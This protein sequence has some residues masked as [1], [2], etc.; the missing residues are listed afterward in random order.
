MEDLEQ[1]KFLLGHSIQA[2]EPYLGSDRNLEH[3]KRQIRTWVTRRCFV[4]GDVALHLNPG[5]G[6]RMMNY[7]R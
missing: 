4:I 3:N 2:T 7:C 1:V 6:E 5:L